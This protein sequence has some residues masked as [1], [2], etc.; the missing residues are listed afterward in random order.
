[1]TDLTDLNVTSLSVNGVAQT[2]TPAEVN[3]L[4]GVTAGTVTASKAVVVDANKD[5][6]DF[7]NLDA[8]N[9]D[10]GASATAGTVDVFPTTAAKGKIQIAAADSAGDTTTTITNASQSGAR[11][12]TIPD[13][14]ASASFV[15]TGS[16]A[17][18]ISGNLTVSGTLTNA[19][20]TQTATNIDAGASGTAG[21]IDIFPTTASKGKLAFTATDNTGDTTT[22]LTNAAYAQATDITLTD[23]VSA[24]AKIHPEAT[25]VLSGDGA[26][27]IKSGVVF[28]TKGSAAAI[29]LADPTTGTDDGKELKIVSTTAFS[30]TV[31]NTTG[32]NGSGGTYDVA[33][34][35]NGLVGSSSPGDGQCLHLVAYTAK[36]F[37]MN[38]GTWAIA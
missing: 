1:M 32:F 22:S 17:Q 9:I 14:G 24:T 5:L 7:R 30:H 28:I 23:P 35:Q 34:S 2:A 11:T 29:T 16:A 19:A 15:M 37:I 31:T 6:G 13:A 12:Y 4:A 3:V 38:V 10:A 33:T 21:S 27:T 18:T 20:Y 36:W 26:I 25:Q 8:V